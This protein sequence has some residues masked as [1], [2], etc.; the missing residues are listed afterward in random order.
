MAPSELTETYQGIDDESVLGVEAEGQLDDERL[1]ARAGHAVR[2]L[3]H[4]LVG[5]HAPPE[6]LERIADLVES[7]AAELDTGSA[8]SRPGD[9]MQNRAHPE[10]PP[11]GHI[12]ES[13]P[14]RPVSGAASPWGVDLVV[15]R[16]GDEAVG[17]CISNSMNT[18]AF[19]LI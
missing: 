7:L 4:A 17:R 5:H 12:M 15:T 9:D 16:E 6:R 18:P 8:R 14:D 11:S 19:P 10:P 3:G 13:F 1:R 2:H